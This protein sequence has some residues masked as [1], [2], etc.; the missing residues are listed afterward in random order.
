M[1][2]NSST[3]RKELVRPGSG[4][5]SDR[6]KEY[7]FPRSQT[8]SFKIYIEAGPQSLELRG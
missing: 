3:Q 2:E 1:S 5:A 7:F 4:P 6:M 8:L